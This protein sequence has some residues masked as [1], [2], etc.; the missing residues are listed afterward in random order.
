MKQNVLG[1]FIIRQFPVI[2]EGIASTQSNLR[3]PPNAKATAARVAT[4]TA[5]AIATAI[6]ATIIEAAATTMILLYYYYN[7]TAVLL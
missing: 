3:I 7:V 5:V 1:N 2:Y 4:A 6:A